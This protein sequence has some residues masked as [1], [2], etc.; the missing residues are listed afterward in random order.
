MTLASKLLFA[1]I[2]AGAIVACREPNPLFDAP[3]GGVVPPPPVDAGT[4][5]AEATGGGGAGG[6]APLA[7]A[8]ATVA[9]AGGSG[10]AGAAGVA[11][12][13]QG[14]AGAAGAG[15]SGAGGGIAAGAGSTF[16]LASG[17][18]ASWDM[19]EGA[20]T[21]IRD[22]VVN[23]SSNGTL[24]NG[25]R[26]VAG[27]RPRSSGRNAWSLGLDGTTGFVEIGWL[28]NLTVD[29]P[30]SV[31]L[32][33]RDDAPVPC[34]CIQSLI[35]L[36]DPQANGNA[37]DG[38]QLGLHN[39]NGKIV[40]WR[41]GGQFIVDAV[42]PTPGAWHHVANTYDGTTETLYVDGVAVSSATFTMPRAKVGSARLGT[43]FKNAEFFKGLLDDVRIWNRAL[44]AVEVRSLADGE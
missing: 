35:A 38:L 44:T 24:T 30:K 23:P 32:W 5:G 9:G 12:A 26:F 20:G 33:Y 8:A 39:D 19:E 7:G 42:Q 2:A 3:D 10:V 17:L 22:A 41:W 29:A 31:S 4:A 37:G 28:E 14:G 15:A 43:H 11:G 6:D 40:L 13:L 36:V 34:T 21:T 18:V 1:M 16:A 27:G 25:A